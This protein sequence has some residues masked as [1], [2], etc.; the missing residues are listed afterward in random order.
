M[1][2]D[3]H[4][5]FWNYNPVKDDW[6]TDDMK[7]LK[8]DFL[9]KELSKIYKEL[10]IS[11]CVAVQADQSEEET[12]FLL[13]LAEKHDFIK[14]VVGWVDLQNP[15]V[16]EHLSYY[17]KNKYFKG[18]R[19]ILQ[20]EDSSF[21]H[22]SE[23]LNGIK[24]LDGLGLSY[25][26]L[27]HPHQLESTAKLVS[28]F[29]DL[30]FV[31]D[32]LAKPNIKMKELKHWKNDLTRVASFTNVHCKISGLVTEANWTA[33]QFSELKPYI[34]VVVE[35][36]GVER[37]MFGSDW[38]V[39]NLA[40]SYKEVLGILDQYLVGFSDAEKNKILALNAVNFY[41]LDL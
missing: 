36:F 11:G 27:I 41:N 4:Q 26:L 32:H 39:S 21:M 13:D 5:H 24:N 28:Q 8:R 35:F 1:I 18:V 16:N 37:V 6:I 40:A 20:A 29:P 10:S 9:P 2:I 33:W 17:A 23:F 25:D 14:G 34:D 38:P 31:I 7:V 3:S 22:K 15:Q 12:I 19:H 30:N